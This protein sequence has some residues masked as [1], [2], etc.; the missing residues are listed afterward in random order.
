TTLTTDELADFLAAFGV[1]SRAGDVNFQTLPTIPLEAGG[2]REASSI[3][4]E[5]AARLRDT[6]LAG[7]V[8]ETASGEQIRVLVENG[9]GTPELERVAARLLED[10]GYVF[11]PGGNAESFDGDPTVV[12]IPDTSE[13]SIELGNAVAETLGVPQSAVQTT[14]LGNTIADVIVILGVDFDS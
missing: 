4:P 1:A 3:D 5:G 9:V 7:S 12:L 6:V 14:D 11:S 8:P 2:A 13:A 10:E